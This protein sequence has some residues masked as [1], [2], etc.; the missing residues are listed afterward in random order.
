MLMRD[1]INS[2]LAR[3]HMTVIMEAASESG[4]GSG[5][6]YV[7]IRFSPDVDNEQADAN[8]YS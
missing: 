3:R 5:F 1:M 2:G 8:T 6:R 7:S 4:K